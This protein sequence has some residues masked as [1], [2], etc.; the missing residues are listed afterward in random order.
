MGT[1][2]DEAQGAIEASLAS[3]ARAIE[4]GGCHPRGV[5]PLVQGKGKD[6]QAPFLLFEAF[7]QAE[8]E[9]LLGVSP[10]AH[11]EAE[12]PLDVAGPKRILRLPQTG[13]VLEEDL[14]ETGDR[15]LSPEERGDAAGREDDPR[16]GRRAGEVATGRPAPF[17]RR[18]HEGRRHG[19]ALE[20]EHGHVSRGMAPPS[21]AMGCSSSSPMRVRRRWARRG[22]APAV[23][24][25]RM[26]FTTSP[27]KPA[28]EEGARRW[29]G[30]PLPRPGCPR[31][32][33][34]CPG[35]S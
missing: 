33:S 7:G 21:R 10:A 27:R 11:A 12:G 5:P 1:T 23:M 34:P 9:E 28:R 3:A 32:R 18:L 16:Q 22:A 19:V 2:S 13:E 31:P 15:P 29:S 30:G 8:E 26:S 24:P 35:T 14:L 25:S 20:A 6:V 17:P 4:N